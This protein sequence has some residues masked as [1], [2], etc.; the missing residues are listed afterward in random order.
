MFDRMVADR[1]AG[2]PFRT[3]RVLLEL[4][5]TPFPKEDL[6]RTTGNGAANNGHG[7]ENGNG[8]DGVNPPARTAARSKANIP[9]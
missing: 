7:A 2:D 9:S 1:Y 8:G 5:E 4:G 6:R 3:T